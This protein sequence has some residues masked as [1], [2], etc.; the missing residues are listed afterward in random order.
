M[1]RDEF[2]VEV[3]SKPLTLNL[4]ETVDLYLSEKLSTKLGLLSSIRVLHRTALNHLIKSSLK[5]FV[6]IFFKDL[7]K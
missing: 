4:M 3:L 6:L 5:I 7:N 1:S 2:T